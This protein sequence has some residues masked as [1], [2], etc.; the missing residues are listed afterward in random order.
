MMIDKL[1]FHKGIDVLHYGC[2]APHAYFIPYHSLQAAAKG[3]RAESRFFKSLCGEWDFKYYATSLDLPDFMGHVHF[4]IA[5]RPG[6][7]SDA[8]ANLTPYELVHF[9]VRQVE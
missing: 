2:E 1:T 6:P 4:Y 7:A 9:A 3:N 8:S 5:Y